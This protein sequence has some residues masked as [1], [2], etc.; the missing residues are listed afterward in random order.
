[1][2]SLI[3]IVLMIIFSIALMTTNLVEASTSTVEELQTIIEAQ[4]KEIAS[5]RKTLADKKYD[6]TEEEAV[7]IANKLK[8]LEAE[9]AD[10][11]ALVSKQ[12]ELI[13]GLKK[14]KALQNKYILSLEGEVDMLKVAMVN[15]KEG[16]DSA[17]TQAN[18]IIRLQGDE[19]NLKDE[20]ISDQEK[21]YSMSFIDKLQFIAIGVAVYSTADL[22]FEV[23]N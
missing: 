10:L 12:E 13:E 15:Q 4:E 1:M 2:I 20:I 18:E 22:V 21:M 6:L 5:L 23:M 9:N 3:L 19:L 17:M 16:F 7:K 8:G 14:E 11:K